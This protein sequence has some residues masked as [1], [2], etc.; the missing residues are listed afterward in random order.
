MQEFVLPPMLERAFI[1][2][3]PARAAHA[4]AILESGI[5]AVMQSRSF[6]IVT[7]TAWRDEP[8]VI[9]VGD[10]DSKP[11]GPIGFAGIGELLSSVQHII[12]HA[13]AGERLHGVIAVGSAS[14]FGSCA[15]IETKPSFLAAWTKAVED[16]GRQVNMLIV[17]PIPASGRPC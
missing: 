17:P 4:T 10:D 8:H 14:F 9:M 7:K 13:A 11:T 15:L 3:N 12:L 5:A 2:L 6:H 16:A 1:Q